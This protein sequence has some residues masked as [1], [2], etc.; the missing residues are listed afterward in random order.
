LE[1]SARQIEPGAGGPYVIV[2]V[3]GKAGIEDSAWFR[4][5]LEVQAAGGAARMIIDLSRLSSMDWWAALI[6]LWV[7]R[8]MHRRGGKLMLAGPRPAVARMLRSAGAHQVVPVY[9]TVQQAISAVTRRQ[10][11]RTRAAGRCATR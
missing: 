3:S 1:I 9:E 10:A 2:S 8:V 7:A 5:L 11:A 6:L 4:Q